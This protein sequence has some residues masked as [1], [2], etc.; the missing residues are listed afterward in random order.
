M[1]DKDQ[2]NKEKTAPTTTDKSGVVVKKKK[3]VKKTRNPKHQKAVQDRIK[4]KKQEL[5]EVLDQFAGVVSLAC[6]KVKLNTDTFY[7]WRKDDK[8]FAEKADA[9]RDRHLEM[10]EDGLMLNAY[11]GSVKAQIFI[12]QS[13]HPEYKKRVQVGFEH[14]E[15]Y[16]KAM[17]QLGDLFAGV[18]KEEEKSDD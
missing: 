7:R 16:D 2:I 12:L 14:Q 9:L 11:T 3:Q 6:K 13:R 15:E 8:E 10:A 4:K 17:K 18:K 1:A 5:L